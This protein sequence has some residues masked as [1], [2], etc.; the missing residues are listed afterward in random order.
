MAFWLAMLDHDI[1]DSEHTNGIISALM[2]LAIDERNRGWKPATL[3]TPIL[4]AMI[5]ISR[6]MVVYK[7]YDNRNAIVKR[8]MRAEF[9][10]ET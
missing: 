7:V 1:G 2:V 9:I 3:Y 8:M 4:S 10:S 6:L 5:T